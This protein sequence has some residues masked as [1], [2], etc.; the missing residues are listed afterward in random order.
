MGRSI[1]LSV[2]FAEVPRLYRTIV[3]VVCQR[4]NS[5]PSP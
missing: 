4:V 5:F 3:R 2:P 1:W